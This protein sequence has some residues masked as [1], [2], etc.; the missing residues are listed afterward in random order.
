MVLNKYL[1]FNYVTIYRLGIL[2]NQHLSYYPT[3]NAYIFK[4]LMLSKLIELCKHSI[5]KI[6]LPNGMNLIL[7]LI[8]QKFTLF[9]KTNT[10][11][12]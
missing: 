2:I 3:Y 5:I 4:H 10:P 11:I 12:E 1:I 9:V 7:I 8:F 6:V